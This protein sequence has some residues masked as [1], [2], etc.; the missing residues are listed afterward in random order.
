MAD[1]SISYSF[2]ADFGQFRAQLAAAGASVKDFGDKLAEDYDTADGLREQLEGLADAAAKVGLTAG[3]GF[4]LSVAAAANFEQA[5]SSVAAATG[6]TAEGMEKIRQAALDAGQETV[7]SATEA[8]AAIEELAKAGVST[9]DILSGGLDGALS[10]AAAGSLEVADAAEAAASAMTQFGLSGGDVPHIADLLAAGAGKAQGSVEDMSMA[11]NQS[12]LVAAQTGL[13]IE[14]T[15][16]A[17]SAFASAGLT[18][19]DAGTSFKTMLQA[20]TPTSKEA[21]KLMDQLGITAYDAQGNFVGLTA[22][23]DSLQAGLKDL[24]VEQQNAALKTI[25]GSDAVRAA[26]VIYDQGARGIQEWIDKTNDAGFAAETA[27]T[28]TDNLMGDLEQLRGA[29]ETALISTGEGQLGPLR[30]WTQQLTDLVN[31]YND[32][33]PVA[34]E[35]TGSFLALTALMAGGAFFSAKAIL[36]VTAM[37]AELAAMSAQ[38][39]LGAASLKGL[40][41]AGLG[42][43]VILPVL[44]AINKELLKNISIG[45]SNLERSID[46]AVSGTNYDAIEDF[47]NQL[48]EIESTQGKI[49]EFANESL[50]GYGTLDFVFGGTR[51]DKINDNITAVDQALAAMVE[52]GNGEKAAKFVNQLAEGYESTGGS[53]ES[54]TD[55]LV[56]Y[57]K[58]V[59]NASSASGDAADPIAGV[60]DSARQATPEIEAMQKALD[61]AR[62]SAVQ[63]ASAFISYADSIAGPK[64][65]L[66]K[67]L[68][69]FEKQLRALREFRRNIETLRKRGLDDAAV[70]ELVAQGPAAAQAVAGL[71]KAPKVEIERLNE[72]VRGVGRQLSGVGQDAADAEA[73]LLGFGEAEAKPK[74]DLNTI[75]FDAKLR[76][77]DIALD[78]ATAPRTVRI[79]VALGSSIGAALGGL[80]GVIL[81]SAVGQADG[82]TVMGPRWPY[83]DKV[84]TALAPGEEVITNRNGEADR[85]RADRA[86]GRIPAYS[87]GGEVRARMDAGRQP[88]AWGGSG[89]G[90][91]RIDYDR[92]AAALEKSR[93]LY[94]DVYMAP[95]DYNDFRRDMDNDRRRASI[96][97]F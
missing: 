14:E 80:P 40:V 2:R 76:A 17:L 74:V 65:S 82:G 16:G 9:E 90:S 88:S 70:D 46:A 77:I 45:G 24:S 84:L 31:V 86:A 63:G 47:I 41:G 61:K 57:K 72:A 29:F 52:S 10:L 19:S 93:P 22:F 51:G 28:K 69:A 25:F 33:P 38:G 58:A 81:G 53:A 78:R 13:T 48:R 73:K 66:D 15:T 56:E 64:F 92:L 1:R 94:G 8:A 83:G 62:D 20:L 68:T 18:G 91:V 23:A 97:G 96:G 12:G 7:Y 50:T 42:L 55:R 32:L 95:H 54:V 89:G 44:G 26:A 35:V 21:A 71:A 59:D 3:A 49:S 37:K 75:R 87:G 85:F 27:A 4:T 67:Y 6:E 60:G 34:H 5:L 43:A 39:A 11:L 30:E 36:S 79:G